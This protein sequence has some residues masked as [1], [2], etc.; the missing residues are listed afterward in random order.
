MNPSKQLTLLAIFAVL[1]GACSEDRSVSITQSGGET[2]DAGQSSSDAGE[3]AC[4]AI[5][6][7]CGQGSLGCCA[8]TFC[9]LNT[10]AL[11][12]GRCAALRADGEYCEAASECA[13]GQCTENLCGAGNCSG[14]NQ[15]C[16][17]LGQPCCGDLFCDADPT[18]YAGGSCITPRQNGEFCEHPQ[19]CASGRCIDGLCMPQDMTGPVS[20]ARVFDEVL[21]PYGCTNGYCHGSGVGGLMM[22]DRASAYA[23]LV[24][25]APSGESCEAEARVLPGHVEES[26][27]FRKISPGVAVCGSKM[28]PSLGGLPPQAVEIVRGW[29]ASGAQSE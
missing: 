16:Y 5:G 25:V 27:I 9:E 21:T 23:S 20:F 13:S 6:E 17:N 4:A 14:V 3:T 1:P 8:E 19:Q 15:P 11:D 22:R 7:R 24:G 2:S 18:S 26:L 12:R 29:I 10:Y 28:P